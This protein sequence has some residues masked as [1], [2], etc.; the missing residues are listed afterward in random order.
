MAQLFRKSSIEKLSSP[1]Q[2]DKSIIV[3]S[4][5]SWISLIGVAVIIVSFIIWAFCGTIPSTIEANGVVFG[6][7]YTNTIYSSSSGIV[8]NIC[9]IEGEKKNANEILC[10]IIDDANNTHAI[11]TKNECVIEKVIVEEGD[12]IDYSDELFGIS[13]YPSNEQYAVLFIEIGQLPA[14]HTGMDVVVNLPAFNNQKY[15]HMNGTII[16]IDDFVATD[17]TLKR[18]L[19]NSEELI[20]YLLNADEPFVVVTCRLQKDDTADNGLFWSSEK[21][22][23]L[24]VND[25]SVLNAKIIISESAPITKLFPENDK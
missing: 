6:G 16:E 25:G 17:S 4:S 24:A 7:E 11:L 19:G 8:T 3:T 15:G 1:D 21:G 20:Q 14:I 9:A 2:L 22:K 12:K 23:K 18:I 10:Y 13:P 5:L